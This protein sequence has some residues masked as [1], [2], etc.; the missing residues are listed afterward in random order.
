[1]VAPKWLGASMPFFL[2]QAVGITVEDFVI[3]L[4]SSRGINETFWTHVLG[5][6]WVWPIWFAFT[7]PTFICWM[8]PAGIVQNELASFSLVRPLALYLNASI[9]VDVADYIV[10]K[11]RYA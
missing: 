9:A 2:W 4:A 3:N 10:P 11:L 7:V 5:Y 6:L 1:M 8:H